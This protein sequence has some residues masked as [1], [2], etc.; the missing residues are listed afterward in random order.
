MQSYR[1][2]D[3]MNRPPEN[4]KGNNIEGR[5]LARNLEYTL[6]AHIVLHPIANESGADIS[7]IITLLPCF[8]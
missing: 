8:P 6:L 4:F 3:L 5:L 1:V 7:L 2:E